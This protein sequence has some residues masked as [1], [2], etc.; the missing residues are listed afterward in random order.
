MINH[1]CHDGVKPDLI[2]TTPSDLVLKSQISPLFSTSVPCL[3]NSHMRHPL[4]QQK[5]AVPRYTIANKY[6]TILPKISS[7]NCS[8]HHPVVSFHRYLAVLR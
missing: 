2:A 7:L 3:Y 1:S 4:I 6:D 5:K 8:A